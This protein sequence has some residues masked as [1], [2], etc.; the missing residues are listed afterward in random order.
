M[1]VP[2][3]GPSK[4]GIGAEITKT[5]GSA[6]PSQLLLAGRKEAKVHPVIKEIQQAPPEV[7]VTFHTMRPLRQRICA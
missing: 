3:T 5:L 6:S 2:I 1:L 7:N 4:Y